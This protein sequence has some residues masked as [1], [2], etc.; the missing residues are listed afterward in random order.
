MSSLGLLLFF[1]HSAKII[2]VI[3]LISICRKADE[4]AVTLRQRLSQY[5][6][7]DVYTR[8]EIPEELH[9]AHNPYCPPILILAK[10]NI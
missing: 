3:I 7:I 8:D 6:D 2:L 1:S 4:I 9:W 10:V 5:D